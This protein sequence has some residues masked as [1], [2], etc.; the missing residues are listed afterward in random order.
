MAITEAGNLAIVV[1]LQSSNE[2]HDA[3]YEAVFLPMVDSIIPIP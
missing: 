3:L 1:L 2:D